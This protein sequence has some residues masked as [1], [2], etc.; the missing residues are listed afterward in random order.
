MEWKDVVGFEGS[1]QVSD[2]GRVR[3]L[4]RR[5]RVRNGGLRLSPRKIKTL[6]KN[7]GGYWTVRLS[8]QGR[9]FLFLV[10][11]LVLRAFVG[12]C[13]EGYVV[14]HLNSVRHD[15]RL[16]NLRY[17]TVEKNSAQ[18]GI[19]TRGEKHGSSKLTRRDVLEIRASSDL[20]RVIAV[21][22]KIDQSWVSRIR[23]KEFWAWL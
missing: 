20:Q 15:N 10:H 2:H 16:E 21:R 14:D 4:A 19:K 6:T 3:S 8:V 22:Y 11:R 17:L 13:P 5:V 9:S 7:R 18:G 12:R 23:K 1:Y